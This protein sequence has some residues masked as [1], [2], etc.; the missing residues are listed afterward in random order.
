M[1]FAVLYGG[2][3]AD[4]QGRCLAALAALP[5]LKAV[6]SLAPEPERAALSGAPVGTLAPVPMMPTR[7]PASL[8]I[9]APCGSPPV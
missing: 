6:A 5:E 3:V 4:W 2:V 8:C 7:W 9:G 1:R